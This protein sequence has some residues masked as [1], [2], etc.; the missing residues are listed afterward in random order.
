MKAEAARR[1]LSLPQSQKRNAPTLLDNWRAWLHDSFPA[2]V[3]APFS[4]RHVDLWEWVWAIV[5]GQRPAPFV[6]IWP[7]GG[8]KSTSAELA[9]VA[10]YQKRIR[11][12]AVYVSETQELADK[13]VATISSQLESIGVDRAVNKYGASKGWRR[14][15]L[16]TADG[17]TVDALGLDTAARGIKVDEQRPDL[18][19]LDDLD[20]RHDSA[21]VTEKKIQSLTTTILPAGSS[22]C[23]VLAVQNLIHANGIFARLASGRADFLA[24]RIISGPYLAIDNFQYESAGGYVTSIS[25]EP[26]WAGQDLTACLGFIRTWGLR[27]FLRECQHAVAEAEGALWH[28]E[29]IDGGRVIEAPDLVRIVVAVDPPASSGEHAAEC[30]IVV[31]GADSAMN[32][33]VLAD[34]SMRGTPGQWALAA[35]RAYHRWRADRIVG[36]TNN[37]GEMVENTLRTVRDDS[38]R[39]IGRA[40]PYSAVHASR[41]KRTR[42]EPV[43]SLYEHGPRVHHVGVFPMLEQ[44]MTTWEPGDDS[45]D[46]LDALVWAVTE[47]GLIDEAYIPPETV[48][49]VNPTTPS[50]FNPDSLAGGR[51]GRGERS[52]WHN[53]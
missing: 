5:P 21:A 43:S 41:G 28:M 3:T 27:A 36:E 15:R 6:A 53:R 47:L 12:Y 18:I 8:A 49:A 38:G 13:H 42:A 32:G 44:Q 39:E 4:S 31:V 51:W 29:W 52:G 14:N 9:V 1:G 25:G 40:I 23:A 45:P 20:G 33:Y 2:Y 7:R 37:G 17:F 34:Y 11:R 19:V 46:R 24:D 22:D 26:T 50:R 10:L 48:K 35:I 16:R 30:G